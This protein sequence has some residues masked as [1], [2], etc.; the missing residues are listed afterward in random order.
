MVLGPR[1]SKKRVSLW[2]VDHFPTLPVSDF[3]GLDL[4]A[5]ECLLPSVWSNQM[6]YIID[7]PSAKPWGMWPWQIFTSQPLWTHL[8]HPQIYGTFSNQ[9]LKESAQQFAAKKLNQQLLKTY[10]QL[11]SWKVGGPFAAHDD[12][13]EPWNRAMSLQIRHFYKGCLPKLQ[14]GTGISS[15]LF[16]LSYQE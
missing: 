4:P 15:C 3:G 7:A 10:V 1:H 6:I 11:I 16:L 2:R 12:V 14:L 13:Q 9:P 5:L 8:C